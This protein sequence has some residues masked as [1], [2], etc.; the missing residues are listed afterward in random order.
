MEDLKVQI[1]ENEVIDFEPHYLVRCWLCE[2]EFE[3]NAYETVRIC[4]RCRKAWLKIMPTLSVTKEV[5]EQQLSKNITPMTECEMY[6]KFRSEIEEM[7]APLV[8]KECDEVI[9]LNYDN[10]EVGLLCVKDKYIQGLYILPEHRRKGYGRKAILDYIK[11][12]GMLK[13]LTI[14]NTNDKAKAFWNN[15]FELEVI[16]D[17]SIDT[18]YKIKALKGG[19]K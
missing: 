6:A 2:E 11:K 7:Y 1:S 5:L 3:V 8:L 17:N 9:K 12:Y 4:N 13:D 14:L 15:L 10:Q 16:K 18:Y 19:T